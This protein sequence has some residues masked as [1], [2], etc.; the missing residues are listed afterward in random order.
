MLSSDDEARSPNLK[1]RMYGCESF[2]WNGFPMHRKAYERIM[3]NDNFSQSVL[4]DFGEQNDDFLCDLTFHEIS[5]K[6]GFGSDFK[7]EKYETENPRV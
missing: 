7:R 3:E 6:Y 4:R 1:I 2:E 5:E